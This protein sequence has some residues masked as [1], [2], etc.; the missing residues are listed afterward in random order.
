MPSVVDSFPYPWVEPAAQELHLALTR[1]HPSPQAAV[2]VAERAGLDTLAINP[3]Q[4]PVAVWHDVLDHAGR[5][6]MTRDLVKTVHDLLNDRNPVRPFLEDLLADRPVATDV[7]PR[8]PDGTP[9]FLRDD[10]AVSEQESLLYHDDLT[11][12]VGR[13]PGLIGTLQR[14]L[15]VAPAVCRLVVDVH[16]TTQ[17]GSAFRIAEDLLLTNWHVVHR[18]GDAVP[19]TGITAEFRYEDDGRGGALPPTPVPCDHE[20]VVSDRTDDW[21]VVRPTAPLDPAWPV[22]ALTGAADP[23]VGAP[24]FIVQHPRGDRKRIGFVRNSVSS[25]DDRVLHY[26]TDTQEGSS[27]SPVFDADGRLVGLHHAGGRP[28]TVAGRPP[29]A[30]NEGIRIPRVLAGLT[31]AGVAVP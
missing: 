2:A 26:L 17:H 22:L 21:A 23:V 9:V 6:G 12:Q 29:M 11:L 4:S 24:A 25:F 16:G 7:E 10:D 18:R 31:A 1:L 15:V 27:G 5:H 30:K 19:A 3:Q 14:L 28:Q 13:V 20:S 8:G